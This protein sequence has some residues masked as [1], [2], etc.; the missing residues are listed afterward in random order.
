MK[1]CRFLLENRPHYGAVKERDGQSWI[2][3]L[4]PRP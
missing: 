3:D 1:Y 2:V 4:T